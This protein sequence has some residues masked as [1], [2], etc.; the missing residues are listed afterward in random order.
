MYK[1]F[2]AAD[3]IH[4]SAA[5]ITFTYLAMR[6]TTPTCC[7]N[8]S[9]NSPANTANLS[10]RRVGS[11]SSLLLSAMAFLPLANSN[12]LLPYLS[13]QLAS[14]HSTHAKTCSHAVFGAACNHWFAVDWL[15]YCVC[16]CHVH[17][18]SHAVLHIRRAHH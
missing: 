1:A 9:S 18:G 15:C 11:T 14:C 17:S 13:Y 4:N 6:L 8:I 3:A 16:K 7:A 2:L 5:N 12:G 10:L